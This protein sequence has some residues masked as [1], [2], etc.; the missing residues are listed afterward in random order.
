MGLVAKCRRCHCVVVAQHLTVAK[1]NTPYF[2]W[3]TISSAEN[4][5]S[6]KSHL[7]WRVAKPWNLPIIQDQ[8]QVDYSAKYDCKVGPCNR[9]WYGWKCSS[10]T[11]SLSLLQWVPCY[12]NRSMRSSWISSPDIVPQ[13]V[14]Q[15]LLPTHRASPS[16]SSM[17]IVDSGALADASLDITSLLKKNSSA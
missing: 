10:T 17:K 7:I 5:Q 13:L 3:T 4:S 9:R 6:W 8:R 1:S 11:Q 2:I 12:K 16:K 15:Y 14:T